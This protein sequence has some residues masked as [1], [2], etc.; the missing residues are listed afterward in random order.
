MNY[1]VALKLFES[2]QTIPYIGIEDVF[3]TGFSRQKSNVIIV[4]NPHFRL[5]PFI[6]PIESRCAFEH[7]RINSNEM[8]VDD[9]KKLWKHVNTQGYYCKLS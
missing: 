7:G 9:S 1:A 3:I 5:K 4:N 8:S 2:S 6:H